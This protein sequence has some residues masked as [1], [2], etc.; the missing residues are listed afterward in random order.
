MHI[1]KHLTSLTKLEK[2][3]EKL[4]GQFP[5]DVIASEIVQRELTV[6]VRK[7]RILDI[8]K[9]LK[10]DPD[11]QFKSVMDITAVDWQTLKDQRFEVVYHVL[12]YRH[13]MRMRLKV[14]VADQDVMP[15]AVP[16]Y[17]GANW[18]ERE[19]FDMFGIAFDDHPDLRRI[20]SD[21]EFEGH[22]L[23]KDFP[24]NGH[25]EVYYDENL[26]RVSYKPVDLPQAFR[27]FDKTSPWEGVA[28]N[29]DKAENP[30]TF[31]PEAFKS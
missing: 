31:N 30:N 5:D 10:D 23:R 19:V 16:V 7:R 4:D 20:L 13:N 21:Y 17:D 1:D 28:N 11:L 6:S 24:L 14:P 25:V 22:P 9:F 15:S 12:S 2:T 18:F 27:E 29:T 8:L 3:L 26:K